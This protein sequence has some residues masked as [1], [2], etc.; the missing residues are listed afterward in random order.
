LLPV[1]PAMHA[2][3]Q[4]FA[5]RFLGGEARR[6]ALHA[7]A[8]GI[9]VTDLIRGEDTRQK[10]LAKALDGACD[11]PN[12]NHINARS[13]NHRATI[14]NVPRGTPRKKRSYS[15]QIPRLRSGFQRRDHAMLTPAKHLS[16]S[17]P[18]RLSYNFGAALEESLYGKSLRKSY[19]P[20][21]AFASSQPN[22]FRR[23]ATFMEQGTVKWF[24]D[25]KG[26]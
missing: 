5:G 6:V 3:P 1:H 8:L 19:L 24:N 23:N 7:V 14:V 17:I 16:L 18:W 13:D 26:Y 15:D 20:R 10:A 12:F 4:R 11:A 9:A 2:R 22:H 25:D 21:P